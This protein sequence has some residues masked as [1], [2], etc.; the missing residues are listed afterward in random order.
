[1]KRTKRW[2]AL[3][4]AGAMTL[5][6]A[7]CGGGVDGGSADDGRSVFRRLYGSEVETLNYLYTSNTN[8]YEMCANMVDC[9]V[10]Y[11]QYGVMQP[12]LAESWEHNDD[13]TE[14]TFHIRQGVKWMDA[15]GNEVADV[16][17]NDWVSSARW[18]ND[19]AN[20]SSNQYMYNGI[21]KNAEAYFNYT[22]YLL[23]SENGTRTTDDEGNP[24]EPV[25]EVSF[26]DVGVKAVDDYTLV[27]TMEA[28]CTYFPTVLSYTT[29]MPVYGPFLEE[30]GDSFGVDN[31]SVLYNG[32]YIMTQF[33]PQNQRILTKNETYWDKDNVFI[34]EIQYLYNT[35]ATQLGPESF[36]RGEVDWAQI[37]AS[38]LS[39]WLEDPERQNM[40]SPSRAN[41]SFSYFFCFNFEPRFDD[42]LD[43]D[44]WLLAVNNENF[45]QSIRYGLDRIN[46]LTVVEPEDPES[47]LNRTITP[48]TFT[49]AAGLDY[50]Q[51]PALQEISS[52]DGFNE[53]LALQYKDAAV[54]E[55]TAAGAT[56]PIQMY[57]RYNPDTANW[58]R[59]CQVIEQQ[60]EGLLGSDYIDIVVEAGPSTNFL[61]TVRRAGDYGFMKCNWGADYADPQTWTDPFKE[62]SNSYNFMGTDEGT[63][64]GQ[65]PCVN[66]SAETQ[67]LTDQYYDLIEAAKAITT[68]T[69]ARYA[70]FAEAEAF[71]IDHAFVIPFSISNDGY[72]ATRLNIFEAQY[73]PYGMAL[74]SYKFQKLREEPMSMDEYNELYAQWET[75]REAALA[76]AEAE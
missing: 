53:E 8:D 25:A 46:A 50:T 19:A 23:E 42:S 73:A 4:L 70:A 47:L 55:L 16:T 28:P 63:V 29:Y 1:M 71:L 51:Y 36:I 59:E 9:L 62:T 75:A 10:E 37:D 3:L 27:Y 35:S 41:V 26:D 54:E 67:A 31:Y 32:A 12:A 60:L 49:S 56:F 58:D 38:I 64:I 48:A 15:E 33:E 69:E 40:V 30:M 11:D 76:A 24:I 65:E 17:A 39:A 61:S 18:V 2:L 72:I 21:V 68:D 43:P 22:A 74:Q 6:L 66:K 14:W 20:N 44:N 7:A 34:D 13:Y 52:S 57:M 45:R 5:S